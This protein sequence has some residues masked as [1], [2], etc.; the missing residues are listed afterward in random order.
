MDC[1]DALGANGIIPAGAGKSACPDT[2]GATGQDHPRGCGEKPERIRTMKNEKGSSPRV[3]GKVLAELDGHEDAWIIPA[4]AGKRPPA[5]SRLSLRQDHPR[6]CGEKDSHDHSSG[7]KGGSS[8]RVRGKGTLSICITS[9]SWIIPAGAGKSLRQGHQIPGL[10]D[11]PRG[12][13]EKSCGIFSLHGLRGSSPRVRGKGSCRDCRWLRGGI[14]P[15]GAG[16]SDGRVGGDGGVEDH[17]RGC[18]EKQDPR[19][20]DAEEPGSSPRVRGKAKQRCT[21]PM[22]T[23]IIPAGAGKRSCRRSPR[24]LS[25]DHPRGCGEKSPVVMEVVPTAGSSPRVR[26]KADER[27]GRRCDSRIIPAGAGKRVFDDSPAPGIEDHPRGC[28][29]KEVFGPL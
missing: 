4:G 22:R 5:L 14:I 1:G 10:G 8:P 25:R 17:P 3:R 26:G 13:G 19:R 28:G 11:H 27:G 16:K 18:G 20:H 2:E 6:G 23:R 24:C 9:P 21:S 7:S 15:A 29:E 12:C